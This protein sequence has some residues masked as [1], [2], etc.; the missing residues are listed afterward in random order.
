MD[1]Y[2]CVFWR[3]VRRG[4]VQQLLSGLLSGYLIHGNWSEPAALSSDTGF[5]SVAALRRAERLG[6]HDAP[7]LHAAEEKLVCED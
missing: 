3:I 4:A 7:T 1:H 2:G 6:V 5:E